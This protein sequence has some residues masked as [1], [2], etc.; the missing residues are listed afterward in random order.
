MAELAQNLPSNTPTAHDAAVA[1]ASPVRHVLVRVVQYVL[2]GLLTIFTTLPPVWL[3]LSSLKTNNEILTSSLALPSGF[4]TSGYVAVFV[5]AQLHLFFLNTVIVS[6]S[7][8]VLLTLIALLAAYPLARFDFPLRRPLTLIFSLGI[9][10]P[11]ITLIVPEVI[12]IRRLGLYD[13]RLALILMYTAIFFPISF[14]VLRSFLLSLPKELE[15]AARIDGAGYFRT[16]FQVILPLSVPGIATV[17]VIL[18][19]WT[20]NEFFYAFILTGSEA[21]RTM[22]IAMR[23]FISQFDFNYP[24]LFAAVTVAMIPPV[25]AYVLFQEQVVSGLTAGAVKS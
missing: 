15:E 8:V 23:F 3:I 25:I 22:Q 21:T 18:F 24:G 17:A 13:T 7:T 2:L 16:L 12:I 4:N 1:T 9:L 5:D 14:L 20:W 19:I 11:G 6:T 10:I